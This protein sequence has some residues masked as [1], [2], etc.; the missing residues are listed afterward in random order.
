MDLPGGAMSACFPGE[1]GEAMPQREGGVRPGVA[2]PSAQPPL[3]VE[4]EAAARPW[5][6]TQGESME[7]SFGYIFNLTGRELG[8]CTGIC[9]A[10]EGEGRAGGRGSAWPGLKSQLTQPSLLLS[11]PLSSCLVVGL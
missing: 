11:L 2:C 9:E 8:G 4:L 10:S 7:T 1:R 6:I 5:S 3:D